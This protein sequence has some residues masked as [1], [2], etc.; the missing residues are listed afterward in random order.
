MIGAYISDDFYFFLDEIERISGTAFGKFVCTSNSEADKYISMSLI[1]S[2]D[3]GE[4]RRPPDSNIDI[5]YRKGVCYL[6]FSHKDFE[7]WFISPTEH[8]RDEGPNW[9][10]GSSNVYIRTEK[11]KDFQTFRNNIVA[12]MDKAQSQVATTIRKGV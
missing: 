11:S 9:R 10:F 8:T 12:F 2:V 7:D 1:V 6:T 5:N 3:C 4:T